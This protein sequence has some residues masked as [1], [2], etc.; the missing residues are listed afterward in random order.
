VLG[1]NYDIRR[2]HDAMFLPSAPPLE[3]L[4]NIY[5]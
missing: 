1:A 3:L 4:E 2:F 5:V